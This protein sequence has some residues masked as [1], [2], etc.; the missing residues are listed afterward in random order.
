MSVDWLGPKNLNSNSWLL[1][2]IGWVNNKNQQKGCFPHVPCYIPGVYWW[3]L[4]RGFFL[5]WLNISLYKVWF[6]AGYQNLLPRWCLVQHAW[7][8]L[9]DFIFVEMLENC[10][11][12][13]L[14]SYDSD[15]VIYWPSFVTQGSNS[16]GSDQWPKVLWYCSIKSTSSVHNSAFKSEITDYKK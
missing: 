6:V 16:I 14:K 9:R 10:F 13:L 4:Y 11:Y 3:Y 7:K 5:Y 12:G 2:K 1:L 15:L 8:L